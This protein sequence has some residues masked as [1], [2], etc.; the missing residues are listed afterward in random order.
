MI[1]L[2]HRPAVGG[3]AGQV[4]AHFFKNSWCP[5]IRKKKYFTQKSKKIIRRRT[6]AITISKVTQVLSFASPPL[7]SP[8]LHNKT[9]LL[10]RGI[11]I[12]PTLQHDARGGQCHSIRRISKKVPPP[13]D[14]CC[15][16]AHGQC[17][18]SLFFRDADFH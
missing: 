17:K 14:F 12:F 8:P 2:G 1:P 4:P 10:H 16:I 3:P 18:L 6:D 5:T 13:Q 9:N 15:R 11:H 7:P